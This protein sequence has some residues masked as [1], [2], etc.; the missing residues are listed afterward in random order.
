VSRLQ[1]LA[2][3]PTDRPWLPFRRRVHRD[4]WP[5]GKSSS[6]LA[7]SF[8]RI[9]RHTHGTL[10]LLARPLN[11]PPMAPCTLIQKHGQED[12]EKS[13]KQNKR[14][15]AVPLTS[16]NTYRK[17]NKVRQKQIKQERGH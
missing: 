7:C 15:E 13:K 3:R 10:K 1:I 9:S 2:R 16:R 8:S 17:R 12:G 14:I 5:A 11:R 6:S 4:L